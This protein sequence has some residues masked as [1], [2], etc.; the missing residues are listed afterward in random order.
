M[1]AL[2]CGKGGS[3]KSTVAA[4]L[5]K[6]MARRGY[7]VLV[8]DSDES[9]Y[10][11]HRQ[12][13]MELPGSL[14]DYFGGKKMM[15]EKMRRS[16]TEGEQVQLFD[17]N[18]TLAEIPAEART[19]KDGIKLLTIGKIHDFGEGCACPMGAL[20]KKFLDN[21]QVGEKEIVIVDTEAGIEHFGRGV[22]AGCDA[23][24]AVLDPS[25]E[26]LLLSK[27]IAEISEKI[28][29]PLYFVLNRVDEERKT[30]MLEF[31][32]EKRVAATIPET[33]EIFR[34]GLAGEEFDF[35]M[36]EVEGLADLLME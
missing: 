26:S 5:A 4:L 1:K 7:R 35:S 23:I 31:L 36:E 11:L 29:K 20:S 16:F 12:L 10:G 34:A 15:M 21:L 8:V 9:N 6:S 14:M 32:D 13:G 18:W 27:K 19:E 3:G 30:A 17:Q 24:L 33:K 28:G 2:V 22:E 25:Y